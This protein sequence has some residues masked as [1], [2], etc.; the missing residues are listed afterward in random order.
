MH[1]Q[2]MQIKLANDERAKTKYAPTQ[3]RNLLL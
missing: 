1:S 2:E 3:K